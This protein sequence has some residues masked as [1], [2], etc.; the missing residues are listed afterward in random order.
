M[1]AR[2]GEDVGHAPARPG[3]ERLAAQRVGQ[4]GRRD[5]RR[6]ARGARGASRARR[7]A[8]CS[9]ALAADD[10]D[11]RVA[12]D[13]VH[14]DVGERFAAQQEQRR[15]E[16]VE[17]AAGARHDEDAAGRRAR[18]PRRV[19]ARD[20][21]RPWR[22]DAGRRGRR[23]ARPRQ[24]P[25]RS[26]ESRSPTTICGRRP[27]VRLQSSPPS[28]AIT[29]ASPTSGSESDALTGCDDD[30]RLRLLH[31]FLRWH[32]PDQVLRVGGAV[33]AL[34]ARLPELPV[35]AAQ[36]VARARTPALTRSQSRE[37]RPASATGS[38]AAFLLDSGV[39]GHPTAVLS[40]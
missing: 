10:V 22:R 25:R 37:R 33:A 32:Y 8:P 24:A 31:A 21:W 3:R 35:F 23:R 1:P 6:R 19:R 28:A 34:S 14:L 13:G 30:H 36:I 39:G 11:E 4:S 38:A 29:T 18:A 12:D 27:S 9:D 20:R 40:A 5:A 7:V 26:T 17:A 16:V 15:R 2:I